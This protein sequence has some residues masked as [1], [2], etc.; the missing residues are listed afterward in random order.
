MFKKRLVFLLIA[1]VM[2]CVFPL[3]A[4][5]R[6]IS[7]EAAE[8]FT[9]SFQ[10]YF[11]AAMMSAFG[12]TPPGCTISEETILFENFSLTD[13]GL[14]EGVSY[15]AI[16]GTIGL[17][18]SE[19]GMTN[20]SAELTLEGGPVKDLSWYVQNFSAE[21]FDGYFEITADG[22]KFHYSYEDMQ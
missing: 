7:D 12:Q 4:Q 20:M 2:I 18:V 14:E 22:E 17:D 9:V 11:L 13:L 15:T 3:S 8:A 1:L 5:V 21:N 10:A 6:E 16:N 19:D